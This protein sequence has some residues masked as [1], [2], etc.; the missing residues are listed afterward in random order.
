M[1]DDLFDAAA[2]YAKWYMERFGNCNP[3]WFVFPF[4][5]PRPS[6]PTRYQTSLKITWRNARAR[7]NVKGRFHDNRYTFVTD[8]AEGRTSDQVIQELAGHVI[9]AD[10]ETPFLC[11]Y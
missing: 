3:E 10:G 1:N 11:P 9:D 8:L 5:K 7:A 2:E 4:G 6:D